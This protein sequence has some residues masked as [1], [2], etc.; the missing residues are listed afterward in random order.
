MD[1]ILLLPCDI[2]ENC[3]PGGAERSDERALQKKTMERSA[4]REV[5]E[6]KRSGERGLQK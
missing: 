1:A 6:W 3:P 5:A 2:G 4:E